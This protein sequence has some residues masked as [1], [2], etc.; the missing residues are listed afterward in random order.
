[1][2]KWTECVNFKRRR[3]SS[4]KCH[5]AKEEEE[6]PKSNERG[7]SAKFRDMGRSE[8]RTMGTKTRRLGLMGKI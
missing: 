1:M 3:R 5:E 7:F 8:R 6:K 4:G 2:G